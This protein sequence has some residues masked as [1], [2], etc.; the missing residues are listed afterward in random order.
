MS[1]TD[2]AFL[3]MTYCQVTYV[4][5]CFL[6][7]YRRK[8]RKKNRK[9][10]GTEKKKKELHRPGIEPETSRSPVL[11]FTTALMHTLSTYYR[12]SLLKQW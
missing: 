1:V 4:F 10:K 3:T 6:S 11:H 7:F 5:L 9:I 12:E 8:K 2:P